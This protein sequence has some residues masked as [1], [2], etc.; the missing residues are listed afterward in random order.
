M[1]LRTAALAAFIAA[2]AA[3]AQSSVAIFGIVDAGVGKISADG[4]GSVTR[5]LSGAFNATRLGFR[6]QED[7][8]GGMWAGFHVETGFLT[9]SGVGQATNTNNQASGGSPAPGGGQGMTFNR[10]S[11]VSLGGGW[12]ELRLGRDYVPSY[13]NLSAFDVFNNVGS[14]GALNMTEAAGLGTGQAPVAATRASNTISYFTPSFSGFTGHVMYALGENSSNSGA[15]SDD[16]RYAG[17]RIAYTEGKLV[18]GAGYGR[19]QYASGDYHQSN[20]GVSYDFAVVKLSFL[21]GR[22]ELKSPANTRQT[23]WSVGAIVPAG[24]GEIRAQYVRVNVAGTSN[25]ADSVA[26]GYAYPFS[27]RTLAYATWAR[28]DNKG[29]GTS[30]NN[31]RAVTTPGG[32]STGYEFGVRHTF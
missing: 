8:G 3:Y 22:E 31:G 25:D 10:K 12:G 17:G 6:G 15:T 28:V 26:L 13:I 11:T 7:L 19:T 24:H 23:H 16:G 1:K 27:K 2:P 20:T 18:A 4:N 32:A 21:V 14:G 9:D 5:V 30:F 29:T